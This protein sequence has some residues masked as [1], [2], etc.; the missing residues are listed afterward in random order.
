MER[1]Q[2]IEQDTAQGKQRPASQESTEPEWSKD[3]ELLDGVLRF[4]NCRGYKNECAVIRAK[5][6]GS[7]FVLQ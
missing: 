3:V 7:V 6:P 4:M 2:Y 1:L 5:H